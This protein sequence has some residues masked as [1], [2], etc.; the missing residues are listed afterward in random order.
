MADP[1]A[2]QRVLDTHRPDLKSYESLYREFHQIPEISTLETA[3]SAKISEHLKKLSADLDIRTGIG[4]TGII[5][6]C[7]NGPGTTA[8]LRADMDGLT[9]LEETGLEYASKKTMKDT[10]MDNVSKPTMHACGH[11]FHVTC[12][13]AAAETLLHARDEWSGTIIFLFQPAEERACG[14]SAMVDDGLYDPKRHACPIPDVLLAQHVYALK[15]GSVVMKSGPIFTAA[16][17]WRITIFGK[18]GHASMPDRCIDPVVI[19][20]HIVVRLQTIV[21][22]EVPPDEQSVV[23]VGSIKA[24]EAPNAIPSQAVLLV[25]VRSASEKWRNAVLHSIKRIVK[26]EC[27]AGRSPKEPAFE[28]LNTYPLTHNDT[29]MTK[30]IQKS[31]AAY[32]GDNYTTLDTP[33]P[34]SEDFSNLATAVGKP[35]AF[36]LWGG[37]DASTWDHHAKEGTLNE[38]AVNHSPYFAPA[39]QPTLTTGVDAMVVAALTFVGKNNA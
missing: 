8:L 29:G 21:S 9:L 28:Q 18:G 36:W 11:D 34:A 12:A 7:E 13:L 25:N 3:T 27:E 23:T 4:G 38:I 31:F 10:H 1:R 15:A 37:V 22:R 2:F 20:G 39:I 33:V 19:A 17:S 6:I 35:Y 16:D 5:A 30:K 26:A 14:A 32:F 24:G